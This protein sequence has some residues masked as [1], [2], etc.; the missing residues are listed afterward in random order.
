LS[1]VRRPRSRADPAGAVDPAQKA[2][3][4]AAASKT[5]ET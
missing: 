4:G 3:A 1:Q 5:V 2:F